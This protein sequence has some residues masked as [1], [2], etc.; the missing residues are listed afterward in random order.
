MCF[1]F[2]CDETPIL[3]LSPSAGS[4]Q[5]RLLSPG[6]HQCL[7]HIRTWWENFWWLLV[8]VKWSSMK[9]TFHAPGTVTF[10]C[11]VGFLTYVGF[12][13]FGLV[14]LEFELRAL[15]LQSRLSTT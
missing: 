2:L 6:A 7:E 8:T 12:V 13:K 14:G 1:P 5:G 10:L 11:P 15:H 4:T 9:Q 3:D